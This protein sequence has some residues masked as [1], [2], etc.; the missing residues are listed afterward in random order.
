MVIFREC[1]LL[2]VQCEEQFNFTFDKR[3]CKIVLVRKSHNA[4]EITVLSPRNLNENKSFGIM[5]T[6]VALR[7]SFKQ[8]M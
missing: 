5:I 4:D 3:M 2:K 7:M 6:K 1:N 8:A